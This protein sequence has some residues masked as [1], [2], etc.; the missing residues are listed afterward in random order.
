MSGNLSITETQ[1]F[2]GVVSV[3]GSF[4]LASSSGGSVPIIRGQV[5]RV[6]EPAAADFVV[7]WPLMRDRIATN[8][9]T[10][11]DN[12]VTAS[13][14]SGVMTVSAVITGAVPVPGSL[15][16]AGLATAG[17][18]ITGQLT[19]NPGGIGTYSVTG[20]ANVGAATLYCGTS[21]N[22]MQ[23]ELTI[24]ADVH[25]PASADNATRIQ[26]LWR[27]QY[28]VSAFQG[29]GYDLAP[30][31]TSDPRQTAFEN[32]EQQIEERWSIDLCLQANPIVT[33]PMQFAGTLDVTT[34]PVD[35]LQPVE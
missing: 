11:S 13:I 22:L 35:V 32:G 34:Y 7:L 3:L 5:N 14:A 17:A 6:P 19:G 15:W 12:Q 10:P 24:Q 4:G 2:T 27:D 31:Y 33:T 25:G 21:A 18:T 28:A 16:G 30:L 9:D 20:A 29:T 23:T 8:Q 1:I 26:A